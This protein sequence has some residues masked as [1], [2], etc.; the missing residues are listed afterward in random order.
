MRGGQRKPA[1]PV[2]SFAGRISVEADKLRRKLEKKLG[3]SAS[4][5]IERALQS[6]DRELSAPA[7]PAE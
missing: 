5:L 2:V 3:I 1:I 7:H 6:L 4:K